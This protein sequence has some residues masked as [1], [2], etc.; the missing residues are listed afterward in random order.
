[1]KKIITIIALL[2]VTTA[3]YSQNVQRDEQGNFY[4]T[5]ASRVPPKKTTYTYTDS[6]GVKYPVYESAK[7]RY[8]VIRVSK[9]TGKEYRY[10]LDKPTTTGK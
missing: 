7:G 8:F 1:M 3:S 10:Y 4:A 5:G 9:N 2:I 6:K